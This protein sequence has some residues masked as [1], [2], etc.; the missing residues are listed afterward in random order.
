MVNERKQTEG[1]M[2]LSMLV[3][4]ALSI[5]CPFMCYFYSNDRM[6]MSSIYAM[7]MWDEA[8]DLRLHDTLYHLSS[9]EESVGPSRL[10]HF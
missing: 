10:S 1:G 4:R 8:R 6:F 9:N 3:Q 5:R 2:V 7:S